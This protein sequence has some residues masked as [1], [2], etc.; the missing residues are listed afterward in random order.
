MKSQARE[1][2]RLSS[3]ELFATMALLRAPPAARRAV[4]H[5]RAT[6]F[7]FGD[8]D[9]GLPLTPDGG[10]RKSVLQEAAAS[11]ALSP[12]WGSVRAR[13]S[14]VHRPV[15]D[16]A[17]I[18]C[19]GCLSS[20]VV[21]IKFTGRFP[22]GTVFDAKS[23]EK[24]FEFQL[25]TNAVV[26]GMERGVKSMKTGERAL[27]RCEPRWAYG[28][29]SVGNKIPANST[30]VYEVQLLSWRKG[31]PIE[32]TDFDM[33]T[34]RASLEGKS[35]GGGETE[36][37]R[38]AEHGEDVMLWVPLEESLGARDV[39]VEFAPKRLRVAVGSTDAEPL[40]SGVL[41]G[42]ANVDE[43]Y[44]VIDDDGPDGARELQVVLAKAGSFTRWDGIIIGE[45]EE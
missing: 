39:H 5:D 29:V 27:L 26:D 12:K 30:L 22:N 33:E 38:W 32:N 9:L 37:Y 44:W 14:L 36:L 42:R 43:S 4:V 41:K 17:E 16:L 45:D 8:A 25:N 15:V 19:V 34:Y 3:R 20:Q 18:L 23:A 7:S 31:P 10:L 2:M 40:V 6:S 28:A 13:A 24:P 21:E 35:A 11:D 1:A